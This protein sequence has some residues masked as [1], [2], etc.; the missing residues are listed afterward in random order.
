ML[1]NWDVENVCIVFP[2]WHIKGWGTFLVS[3]IGVVALTAG[4]ELVREMS[5]RYESSTVEYLNSLPSKYFLS[6]Q[7]AQYLRSGEDEDH[8]APSS[9]KWLGKQSNQALQ[10]TKMIKAAFYATQVFYSFFIM[11]VE[12]YCFASFTNSIVGYYLWPTMD[13]LCWP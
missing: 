1:F 5:R 3:L 2:S 8:E 12:G 11:W 9:F 4:Y 6:T 13:T 10:K 7:W